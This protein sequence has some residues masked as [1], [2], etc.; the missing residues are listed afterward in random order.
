MLIFS[1]GASAGQV[2]EDFSTTTHKDASS[3]GAV[4]NLAQGALHPLVVQDYISDATDTADA[5]MDVGDGS[6][7]VFDQSTYSKF[8]EGGVT[9]GQVITIDTSVHRNL[10]L[11]SFNL[12]SG[13]TIRGKGPYPLWIKVQGSFTNSGSIN[14]NGEDS[15]SAATSPAIANG[16]TGHCGGGSGGKGGVLGTSATAGGDG[17]NGGVVG[18]VGLG[19]TAAAL[20]T[21]G[22]GGGAFNDTTSATDGGG[23]VG[24]AG[25]SNNDYHILMFD[26]SNGP[27]G[28]AGGGGGG[29]GSGGTTSRGA[30]G[31]AGGGV[32]RISSVGAFFNEGSILA[33]GGTGGGT[34]GLNG[35]GGGGGGGGTIWIQSATSYTD[36]GTMDSTLGA[37]GGGGGGRTGGDGG[38]GR[39]WFGQPL[40]G[41]G[42]PNP[43]NLNAADAG[44]VHYS[45]AA[46]SVDTLPYDTGN[47]S[48]SYT[49]FVV[50]S[51]VTGASSIT[52]LV[53]GS[54][55][56]FVNDTT[57]FVSSSNF[58]LLQGKRYFKYRIQFTYTVPGGQSYPPSIP[59]TITSITA[60]FEGAK[61][62]DFL[63]SPACGYIGSTGEFLFLISIFF[64]I[65][66]FTSA[67]QRARIQSLR[68]KRFGR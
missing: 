13:W 47:T 62:T 16:G 49:S 23:N 6:D 32:I 43:N 58:S 15:E 60:N 24:S 28:G 12:A 57:G 53:A 54:N 65:W 10:K 26:T 42:S 3:N 55:D 38:E 34:L 67:H 7:G 21:G 17:S 5:S 18:Q 46:A 68:T 4:W 22:G 66:F 30:G 20:G 29:Y 52:L 9:P 8:S 37:G 19:G 44:E 48:P 45:V 11:I 33:K 25:T 39:M 1:L 56:S 35:G 36:N 50:S 41:T 14:C 40:D 59:L 31:G 51:N 27:G 61:Q 64:F 2:V 63:F